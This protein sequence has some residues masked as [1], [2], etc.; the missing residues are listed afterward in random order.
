[1]NQYCLVKA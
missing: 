1:M